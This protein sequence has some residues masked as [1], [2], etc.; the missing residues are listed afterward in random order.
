LEAGGILGPPV[1]ILQFAA[2][3]SRAFAPDHVIEFTDLAV[4]E[5]A[6]RQLALRYRIMQDV[7]A[8]V[9]AAADVNHSRRPIASRWSH[10]GFQVGLG[11]IGEVSRH[12]PRCG[13]GGS[14]SGLTSSLRLASSLRRTPARHRKHQ[15]EYENPQQWCLLHRLSLL[16]RGCR[17]I[18]PLMP[19]TKESVLNH[20][21]PCI[22]FAKPLAS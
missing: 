2:E 22:V 19:K 10:H 5:A 3:Q 21:A 20:N 18:N 8:Q 11:N 14:R 9:G 15:Q 1:W 4:I 17:S 7:L 12:V 6:G 16:C 13:F